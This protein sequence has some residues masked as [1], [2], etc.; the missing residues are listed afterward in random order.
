MDFGGQR[1][2]VFGGGLVPLGR[3]SFGGSYLHIPRLVSTVNLPDS[4][5]ET[6]AR[7]SSLCWVK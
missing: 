1:N 2:C 5:T 3:V 6:Q 7:G 4:L